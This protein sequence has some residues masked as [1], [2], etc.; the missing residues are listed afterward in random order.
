M[1]GLPVSTLYLSNYAISSSQGFRYP[2]FE[3]WFLLNSLCNGIFGDL[4]GIRILQMSQVNPIGIHSS[5]DTEVSIL[6][7]LLWA[8]VFL[9]SSSYVHWIY[10]LPV[11]LSC[12]Q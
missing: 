1:T 6:W 12:G 4:Y 7:L 2:P 8:F 9:F 5:I 3:C 10:G 11:D